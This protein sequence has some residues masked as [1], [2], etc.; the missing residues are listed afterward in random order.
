VELRGKLVNDLKL[1]DKLIK[2]T[3]KDIKNAA[4]AFVEKEFDHKE[5]VQRLL[6]FCSG[7][8]RTTKDNQWN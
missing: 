7:Q 5:C 1:D 6:G 8:L 3:I 4:C 2:K